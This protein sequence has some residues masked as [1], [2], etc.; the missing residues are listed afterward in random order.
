MLPGTQISTRRAQA[1]INMIP[2]IDIMLVLLVI[3]LVA[4]P[5]LTQ[6]VRVDLPQTSRIESHP[7]P[8]AIQLAANA[9]GSLSWDG[10]KVTLGE[11]PDRMASAAADSAQAPEL[12]IYADAKTPYEVVAKVMAM[13]ARAGLGHIGFISIPDRDG[14]H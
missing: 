2:M 8:K 7:A 10:E 14:N 9:D 4:A 5:M 13:A 11:L 1:E 3:L 12:H 6:A